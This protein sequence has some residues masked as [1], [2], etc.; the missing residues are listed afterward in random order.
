[1]ATDTETD[2]FEEHR[3][4]LMGVAYRMLGR[5]TDAEDV[6]QEAWLRWS[7]ADRSEVREPRAYLV[8]V[9]TRLAIDRLRQV[10][11]RGETYVG[12]WLPEPYETH[13][14]DTVPDTAEQAVLADSVSLAVLVV[15]ESLSPLERAVFVLREAFGYPYADIAAMLDRTEPAVR[16]LAGRARR[17]VDERRPRYDVDPV[18]RRDLTER[19]LSAA[20][21]GDLE[22]LMSLLA[23]DVRLVGDSGGKT[24][25]PLR[26]LE[27]A[28]HVGRF[29]VGVAG[30]GVPDLTWRFLELNGGPAVL[31]LT[32]GKPDSVFQ[33]D[34]LDGR[35]QSVYIIRNPD[36]LRALSAA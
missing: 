28:D 13:F 29:I 14:G 22:A 8:R 35:I 12:P 25:A 19:F 15:M 5:V 7:A 34:V 27:S 31:V 10:K 4:V 36:K 3:P 20:G 18:L 16:Q 2:V 1:M 17:H 6:V 9:T 24:K 26:V 11:A 30:R 21:G 33:M 32:G 23:P